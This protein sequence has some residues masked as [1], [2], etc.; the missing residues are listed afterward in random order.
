MQLISKFD[1]ILIGA[2]EVGEGK[3][4][5]YYNVSIE[6]DD[7]SCEVSCSKEVYDSVKSG[8]VPK[9]SKAVFYAGY[10]SQYQSYKVLE[11]VPFFDEKKK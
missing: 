9:Y 4:G 1:A 11:I 10:N 5:K 6:Q 2:K 3:N 7:S 8:L